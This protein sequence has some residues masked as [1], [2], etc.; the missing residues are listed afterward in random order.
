MAAEHALDIGQMRGSG[1]G[2]RITK[3]DVQQALM[4]PPPVLRDDSTPFLSPIVSRLLTEHG[5]E[6]QA[7]QGTGKNGRITKQDVLK[8]LQSGRPTDPRPVPSAPP[9]AANT[10]GQRLPV[11][12][13]RRSI[14]EHMLRSVQTSPHVTTVMQADLS[15]VVGHREAHKAEFGARGLHL[16]Y[17]PYFIMASAQALRRFPIVNSQWEGETIFIH[18]AIH[19]GL[20]VSLGQEGLLVPV[21]RHADEKNLAGLAREVADLAERGRTRRLNPDE[22][23]GG[24]FSISNHGTN[25]SLFATPLIVQP[26]CAIL[27]VGKIEKRALVVED[28]LA[29][30]PCAYLSLTFDHRLIDGDTADSFLSA[31]KDHLET[32][33]SN[34]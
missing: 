8:A 1:S 19:I 23:V 3:R 12:A 18:E 27:G 16:S 30:R 20:A 7:I 10:A 21:I 34:S 31:I 33:S 26:Q 5:L 29:L 24:T 4:P 25:G 11:S 32:W 9:V 13:M 2:G 17:T 28:M 15:R 22:L 6:A 14:A